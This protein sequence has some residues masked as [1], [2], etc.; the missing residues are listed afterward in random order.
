VKSI[1]VGSTLL[2][3]IA[4]GDTVYVVTDGADLVAIR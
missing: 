1:K 4:M 3:P 2:G